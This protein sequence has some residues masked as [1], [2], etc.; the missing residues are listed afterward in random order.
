MLLISDKCRNKIIEFE[1]SGQGA[2]EAR[3]QH[4][5]V[6]GAA[7]GVTIGIGYDLGSKTLTKFNQ[8][9][10]ELLHKDE[11]QAL[12]TVLGIRG[13]YAKSLLPKVKFV[14]VP[15]KA[16]IQVFE[17]GTLVET[18]NAVDHAL[19]N[20]ELL[21]P[22]S[23]GSL[24][25]LAYNRGADFST[26]NSRRAEM[27]GIKMAMAKQRFAEIPGLILQMRRLWPDLRGLCDRRV[28]EAATFKIGLQA[29]QEPEPLP[30][31]PVT[32]V[33][34]MPVS[35]PPP[36]PERVKPDHEDDPADHVADQLMQEELDRLHSGQR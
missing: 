8:D 3:W 18:I 21:S 15:W 27:H 33:S 23:F 28:W 24:V 6:P 35:K 26:D 14:T 7:S 34:A 29:M 32:P 2:Y 20:C 19:D 13:A 1:V 22:D 31:P 4:P 17:Q 16:A 12:R 36:P 30:A 11:M 9:W 5:I 10:A 25:S